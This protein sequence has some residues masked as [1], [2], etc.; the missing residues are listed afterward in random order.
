[1]QSSIVDAIAT[2]KRNVA[3]CLLPEDIYAACHEA[4]HHWRERELGPVPTVLTFL[5]QIV[6]GNTACEHA[7]SLSQVSVSASAYCQA[8][9]RLPLA[10][11]E[12]LLQTTTAVARSGLREPLWKGHRTFWMDGSS[13]SMPDTEALQKEFGQPGGQQPGCGFPI[14]KLWAMFDARS[15]LLTKLLIS[16]LRTH[17]G[18]QLSKLH[19]EL[20]PG[21][22]AVGDRAFASYAHL[23]QLSRHQLHGLFRGH[24][25]QLVSFRTDR[26]LVG[27]QPKGTKA[28]YASSRLRRK[29]GKYDQIVEYDKPKQKPDLDER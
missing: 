14:A 26:K 29:L 22:V 23:A 2:I 9:S 8:R 25:R 4:N 13:A 15:G 10:V 12:R 5:T 24:Q 7:V 16:P 6:H 27:K 1:M 17:E 18:S 3:E 21:D 19:P 11:F 28:K 20:R